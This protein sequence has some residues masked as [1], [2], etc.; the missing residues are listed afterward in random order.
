M[1][2]KRAA[3]EKTLG[4]VFSI[5]SAIHQSI[6]GQHTGT[7]D[8]KIGIFSGGEIFRRYKDPV[9]GIDLG[10][11]NTC[12]AILKENT[13]Y[14]IENQRGERTTPSVVS[15]IGGRAVVGQE[16]KRREREDPSSAI[17]SSKRLIGKKY[18]DPEV[19]EHSKQVGYTV[20]PHTNGDAWVEVEGKKYS[21]Q[22]IGAEILKYMKES[23]E[24]HLGE[25]IRRAIITVPAYFTDAQRKATKIAGE[26]AGLKVLRVVNEPTA[27]ALS[28]GIDPSKNG[29]VA[30]YDLGGGTF[31]VSILEIKD[32]VFEVR[33]TNG[34][35]HLGGEDFDAKIVE[36]LAGEVSRQTGF[37][38]V[39][40]ALAMQK[41][42]VAAEK[43]KCALSTE[44]TADITVPYIR[45]GSSPLHFETTLNR[46]TLEK[47]ADPLIQKTLLPC[48][49]AM[50]DAN[51][52]KG[53]IDHVVVVGGMTRMPAVRK[54]VEAVFGKPPITGVDPDEAVAAGAAIQ[55]GIL[56]G[57][58]SDLLLIDVAP[59][60]LGIETLG[61][62]FSKIVEKNTPIPTRKTQTFTTS[63]DS[64]SSV[65]IKIYEGERPLVAYNKYLGEV[66]LSGIPPL[67]KGAP[68]IEVA[69]EAD[70]DGIYTVTAKDKDTEISRN[71]EIQPSGGLTQEEIEEIIKE[72]EKNQ[73]KDEHEKKL[74]EAK[75]KAEEYLKE[76]RK[77]REK[78]ENTL[79]EETKSVLTEQ[80]LKLQLLL[81]E[82]AP[83]AEK[84]GEAMAELRKKA[85]KAWVYK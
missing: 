80:A 35:N 26:I 71:I 45:M 54:A 53:E 46:N 1:V 12:A 4:D 75:Q 27:A 49:I 69:F 72:A 79:S 23:A 59:L 15:F 84:I 2:L 67:P 60:S 32:G 10:T 37:N 28:Y 85:G 76:H 70:A 8:N 20:A 61:G 52:K 30:V 21:P 41:L 82:R 22:Q 7:L 14:I 13:P 36:H 33:A 81:E 66:V 44:E 74:V 24:K 43:A 56:S 48:K 38:P 62:I 64:Q 77:I 73:I 34:N 16:A 5:A 42:R 58:V 55:G 47:I 63:E 11:T 9:L 3:T 25:K 18:T 19:T 78:F 83:T 40:D 6:K 50:A 57:A 17:S 29:T 31:D 65:N 68:K 51:V 39:H